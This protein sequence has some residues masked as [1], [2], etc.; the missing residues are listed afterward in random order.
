MIKKFKISILG[1]GNIAKNFHIPAWLKNNNCNIVGFCD[2]NK[3]KLVQV[4]NFF[5]VKKYFKNYLLMLKKIDFD[6]INIC[7]IFTLKI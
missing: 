5:K 1:T 2:K 7:S 3:K 4:K 6:I